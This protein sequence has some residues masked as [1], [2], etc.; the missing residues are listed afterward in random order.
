MWNS[1]E[2]TC[3]TQAFTEAISVSDEVV[4]GETEHIPPKIIH[5]GFFVNLND[6]TARGPYTVRTCPNNSR[7]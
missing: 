2:G 7:T 4:Q 5:E 6:R 3:Q 1:V